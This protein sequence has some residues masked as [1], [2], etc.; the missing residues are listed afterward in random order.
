VTDVQENI[1]RIGSRLDRISAIEQLYFNWDIGR[2][3]QDLRRQLAQNNNVY[4]ASGQVEEVVMKR[5]VI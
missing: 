4:E 1:R 3:E 2:L 5:D